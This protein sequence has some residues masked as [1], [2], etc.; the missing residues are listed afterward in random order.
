MKLYSI[1][2]KSATNSSLIFDVLNRISIYVNWICAAILILVSTSIFI[3]LEWHLGSLNTAIKR[4]E[5]FII[6]YKHSLDSLRKKLPLGNDSAKSESPNIDSEFINT[7]N[8][9][10]PMNPE[11]EKYR[12]SRD[13]LNH[14]KDYLSSLYVCFQES[15]IVELPFIGVKFHKSDYLVYCS[16]LSLIFVFSLFLYIKYAT[17]VLKKIFNGNVDMNAVRESIS[18]LFFFIYP[19]RRKFYLYIELIIFFYFISCL[20]IITSDFIDLN[21]KHQFL[22]ESIKDQYIYQ[23]MLK[24]IWYRR[25]LLIVCLVSGLY[26]MFEMYKQLV[27]TRNLL[28]LI[29]WASPAFYLALKMRFHNSEE[30][31]SFIEYRE[32]KSG[33]ASQILIVLK[34]K[35]DDIIKNAAASVNLPKSLKKFLNET[36]DLQDA[37]TNHE[38]YKKNSNIDWDAVIMSKYFEHIISNHNSSEPLLKSKL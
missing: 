28:I 27:H 23:I 18:D 31:K 6:D 11:Y 35:N 10:D 16:F 13:T 38:M 14:H 12:S 36:T 2:N 15:S 8:G 7:P 22:D 30:G 19:S 33:M 26:F 3:V 34:D 29:D 1:Q 21:S 25:T 24:S 32:F 37:V 17:A 20:F 9:I 5:K 4:E